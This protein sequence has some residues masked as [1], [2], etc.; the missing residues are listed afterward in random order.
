L[1]TVILKTL[2][3]FPWIS[4]YMYQQESAAQFLQKEIM[5]FCRKTVCSV[6]FCSCMPQSLGGSQPEAK[7]VVPVVRIVGVPVRRLQVRRIVVPTAAAF[8]AVRPFVFLNTQPFP[9]K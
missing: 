5:T 3:G 1:G 4:S 6:V 8:H 9:F 2:S 7:I